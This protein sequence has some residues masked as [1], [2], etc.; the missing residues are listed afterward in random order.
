MVRKRTPT[1][2]QPTRRR[3]RLRREDWVAAALQRLAASG[4][5]AIRVEALA[6]ELGVTKGS[7]YW[8]FKDRP[9][10]LEAVLRE[11]EATTERVAAPTVSTEAAP[12]ARMEEFLD[13]ITASAGD[14]HDVAVEH[15]VLAWAQKD[16]AVAERVAAIEARRI[17][18]AQR[19][20]VEV[21]F[22]RAEAAAWADIGYT[23][24]VGMMNRSLRDPGFRDRRGAD[25]L[26]RIVEAAQCLIANGTTA[27]PRA[28]P[29]RRPPR[30]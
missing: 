5:E 29:R 17:A 13:L 30:T 22:P 23:T 7:F 4:V 19:L 12:A 2:S 14:P 26:R 16:A 3:P 1:K 10:L 28:S 18:N 8:H 11:W 27:S 25:D 21:G 15:A 20:L 6:T 9:A 24:F